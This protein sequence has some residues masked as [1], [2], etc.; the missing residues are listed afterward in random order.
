MKLRTNLRRLYILALLIL[1]SP[2]IYSLIIGS[3]VVILGK[4]IHFISAGYLVKRDELITTGPY[5]FVRH[6]FYVGSFISDV[7][8]SLMA[9]NPYVPLIYLPLFYLVVIPRRVRMEEE[10]LRSKFGP[11]YEEYR[12]RVPRY[13]P[14]WRT[15]LRASQGRFSWSQ[16]QEKRE[17]LRI[18]Y[19]LSLIIV[20]YF[21][22]ETLKYGS[23]IAGY[24]SNPLNPCFFGL[25]VCFSTFSIIL[26]RKSRIRENLN[27]Q[28]PK[29]VDVQAGKGLDEMEE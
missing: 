9:L 24:L 14:S 6:P 13:L 15:H 20:F 16:V 12:E 11:K 1:G 23:Y 4:L 26:Q 10:F 18:I 29:K 22:A 27:A 21:R 8:F 28:N 2:S 7:G 3:G 19:T 25:L 17:V 5:R